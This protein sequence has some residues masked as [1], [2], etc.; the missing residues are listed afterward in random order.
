MKSIS[1]KKFAKLLEKKGWKLKRTK[2][3]HRVYMKVG[4]PARISVPIHKNT[5]LKI[6]LLKHLMKIA[7]IEEKT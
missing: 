6:G 2:G 1:G 4:N 5:S 3:S 7:A